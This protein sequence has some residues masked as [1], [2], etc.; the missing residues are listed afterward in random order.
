MN[1]E[2]RLV[3]AFRSADT[4]EPSPD[5]WSRVVHSIDEDRAHRRRVIVSAGCAVGALALLVTVGAMALVDGPIGS[6]VRPWVMEALETIALVTFVLI[7]GPAIR[8]FG[9]G[10]AHDLWRASPATASA[11]LRLL[12]VAYLLV[13]SGFILITVD[14]ETSLPPA[15]TPATVCPLLGIECLTLAQQLENALVR[16]GGL[17]LVIGLLHA[18][19]IMVLPVVALVSNST[20]AGRALPRWIVTLLVIA[21]IGI[22]FQLL[23]LLAIGAGA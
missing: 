10:Y 11:L 23:M 14:F 6:L 1:I 4:V 22:G 19:T 13:F 20:R 16:I 3:G 18:I 5:L 8:R 7:L 2:Q 9:R 21:G 15:D 17:L 12:D